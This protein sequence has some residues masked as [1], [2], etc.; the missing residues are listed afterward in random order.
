M[1]DSSAS[2]PPP[3]SVLNID[4]TDGYLWLVIVGGLLSF[5]VAWGIGA[6][7]VANAFAT[8]VGSRALRLWQACILAAIFEFLGALLLGAQVTETVRKSIIQ[9]QFFDP[10]QGGAFN[11]PEVLM[12][13]FTVALLTAFLWLF[14]ATYLYLPVS[15]T[16]TIIGSLIG[17]GLAFAGGAG[18]VW[19]SDGTGLDKL[20]GV[21]GVALSWIISPVVSGIFAVIIFLIV[22]HTV[23]RRRNPVRNTLR[24]MPAFM[25]FVIWINCWYFIDKGSPQLNLDYSVGE[26]LGIGAAAGA[27][28]AVL[29]VLFFVPYLR[30]FVRR[31]ERERMS[32]ELDEWH[33]MRRM[34]ADEFAEDGNYAEEAEADENADED[35]AKK[36]K[37]MTESSFKRFQ[38][39]FESSLGKAKKAGFNLELDE[40]VE[41]DILV[42]HDAAEKFDES[43]ERT[44]SFAQVITACF[45]SFA[46]GSNDVANSIAPF[47]SIYQLYQSDGELSYAQIEEFSSGGTFTGGGARDGESYSSGDEV[48]NGESSCGGGFYKC[49]ESGVPGW[50]SGYCIEGQTDPVCSGVS[51][52]TRSLY[53]DDGEF[54]GTETCSTVCHNSGYAVF[55]TADQEVPIWILAMG[56][57]GI[58][59]GLATWGYRIIKAIGVRLT[60]VTPSRGMSIE[61]GAAITVVTASRLGLPVSTTQCQVGA[62][63]GVGFVE[64]KTSTVNW[65][66]FFIIFL[67]WVATVIVAGLFSAIV[68]LVLIYTP[69]KFTTTLCP[70]QDLSTLDG[71]PITCDGLTGLKP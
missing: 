54:I 46:H 53:D 27:G 9:V 36:N 37:M 11:G 65:L 52:S 40:T 2:I 56:G 67:G 17:V 39:A 29:T 1:A 24:F 49:A 59:L 13:A 44:F 28:A 41:D 51:N 6:N 14:L 4:S 20:A 57:A 3:T 15:T 31:S 25:F 30:N 35:L 43:A 70:G 66:S 61:L 60:K 12:T 10:N 22:R 48:P 50:Q 5:G 34:E 69:P 42:L 45:D 68:M 16:H 71:T 26:A 33:T 64:L 7:D 63:V 62:T 23:L 8:S 32:Y 47:T 58:V 38:G 55:A 21:L 18:V 19:I